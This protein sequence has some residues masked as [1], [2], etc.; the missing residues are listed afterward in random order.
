M[1][2]AFNI[3]PVYGV[4]GFADVIVLNPIEFWTGSNPVAKATRNPDG[5]IEME[6][7]GV[8]MRLVPTGE[9]RFDMFRDGKLAGTATMTADRGLVFNMV[10]TDQV[11]R[12][13][14][15]DVQKTEANAA[16]LQLAPAQ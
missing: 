15:E 10:G 3:I 14:P 12:V 11:V 16:K 2:W 13:T 1:F 9:N 5:S 8:V 6:R 7:D 4:L